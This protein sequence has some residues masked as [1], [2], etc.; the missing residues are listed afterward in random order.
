[1]RPLA[2]CGMRGNIPSVRAKRDAVRSQGARKS[3]RTRTHGQRSKGAVVT[4][5]PPPPGPSR[6]FRL[7]AAVPPAPS[8]TLHGRGRGRPPCA[9]GCNSLATCCSSAADGDYAAPAPSS[10]VPRALWAARFLASDGSVGT[11]NSSAHY[12]M[13][14]IPLHIPLRV[15]Y[16]VAEI[17]LHLPLQRSRCISRCASRGARIGLVVGW[18]RAGASPCSWGVP[19]A[20]C[21]VLECRCSAHAHLPAREHTRPRSCPPPGQEQGDGPVGTQN[22]SVQHDT[23]GITLH[24]V[25][26]GISLY[27]FA[28]FLCCRV[29]QNLD[30]RI[31]VP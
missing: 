26:C 28:D 31:G 11:Q 9:M 29:W 19:A 23:Q 25:A 12:D 15:A 17:P 3:P 18:C 8:P 22:L 5:P 2:S 21:V 27:I 13:E 10:V 14:G 30:S 7:Q 4:R 20:E 6:S 24:I 16:P 1:M